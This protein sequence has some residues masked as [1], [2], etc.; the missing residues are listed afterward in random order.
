MLS[1]SPPIKGVG[2]AEYYLLLAQADYYTAWG[3]EP[4]CWFGE[5]ARRL[6]LEGTILSEAYENLLWGRSPDGSRPLVQNA[7]DEDR[8]TALDMTFS[9]PKSVSVAWALARRHHRVLQPAFLRRA[10]PDRDKI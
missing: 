9:A 7:G 2:H 5:G 4:G 1:I 8:Q 10:A 3:N 6:G